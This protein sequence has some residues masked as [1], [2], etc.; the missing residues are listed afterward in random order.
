[1]RKLIVSN[2]LSLDGYYEG[3]DRTL[4]ALFD[5]FHEDY[6]GDE[7]F[8]H[9][10]AERLRAADT[11]L[12]SGRTSFLGNMQYWSGV[13]N[14]PNSTVI[15][16]EIADLQKR[17][18]KVVISDHLTSE[19]LTPWDNTRIIKRADTYKEIA[20]LKQQNGRDIFLFASRML[21]NDLLVHDLVDELHLTIFP[22]IAGGG[23]PLFEGRPSVSLKLISTRT[24][25]GSGNILACYKVSRKKS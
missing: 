24:W 17:I 14:D 2:L 18:E 20:A 23:T 19:E 9:Y 5:Y 16:R 22:V 10:N 11:L 1:M 13:P 15:R 12:L 6:S 21:W 7:N 25:Q 8:D 4:N 3:K